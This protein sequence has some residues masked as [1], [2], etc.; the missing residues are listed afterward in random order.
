[1]LG[2]KGVFNIKLSLYFTVYLYN[3]FITL[4]IAVTYIKFISCLV[5]YLKV[6]YSIAL[7]ISNIGINLLGLVVLFT[8]FKCC[9]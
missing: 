9:L 7:K 8:A 3:F 1:M 4:V 6:K 5:A 2:L